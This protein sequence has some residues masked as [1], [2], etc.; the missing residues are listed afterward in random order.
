[1][2]G[3]DACLD[4]PHGLRT[5]VICKQAKLLFW[6][7]ELLCKESTMS[8]RC[9]IRPAIAGD[10]SR[11]RHRYDHRES[12][13]KTLPNPPGSPNKSTSRSPQEGNSKKM[14][15]MPRLACKEGVSCA[16]EGAVSAAQSSLPARRVG[17][18]VPVAATDEAVR[19]FPQDETLSLG[20]PPAHRRSR[21]QTSHPCRYLGNT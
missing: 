2:V 17:D 18:Q 6:K 7:R 3:D 5:T 11:R 9:R 12:H 15:R 14:Q 10:S 4:R 21:R 19:L 16:D 8:R 1:M 20:P 13:G